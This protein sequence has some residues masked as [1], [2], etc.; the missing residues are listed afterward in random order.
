MIQ[1][2]AMS[3]RCYGDGLVKPLSEIVLTCDITIPTD[4]ECM[5]RG[6]CATCVT[7]PLVS[8]VIKPPQ[9]LITYDAR[10]RAT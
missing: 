4:Y 2:R 8:W 10:P 3:Y 5:Y 1:V 7:K 9:N 6:I